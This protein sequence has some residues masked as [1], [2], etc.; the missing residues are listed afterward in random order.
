MKTFLIGLLLA[1]PASAA[2]APRAD[3]IPHP[4]EPY[5][6]KTYSTAPYKEIWTGE[7]VVKD[8]E[9]A[10]PKLV[11]AVE[12]GGGVLTQPL[13][14]FVSSREEHTQQ[15]AFSTSG[16]HAKS[17]LKVLRK[18]GTMEPPAV[19]PVGLPIPLDEIRAKIKVIM[20]EKSDHAAELAKVPSAAA[21]QEEILE[22]LL[23]VE[24]VAERTDTDVRV[25]LTLRQK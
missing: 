20:K 14:T 24:E 12:T 7:L 8:L 11:A 13:A 22:H 17:L 10:L 15:L 4:G 25:N 19:R 16:K 23:M 21:A 2:T 3:F 1:A 9:S 6:F 5:W 18:F